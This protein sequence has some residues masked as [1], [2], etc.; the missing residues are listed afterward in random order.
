ML[1]VSPS[2]ANALSPHAGARAYVMFVQ[3]NRG[4]ILIEAI[5][6]SEL[7]RRLGELASDNAYDTMLIG[8]LETST[9]DVHAKQIHEQCEDAH[10][11]HSWFQPTGDLLA[12]VQGSGQRALQELLAVTHPAAIS[13]RIVDVKEMADMLG[14]SIPTVRRMVKANQIPV[15]RAPD[16]VLR[17]NPTD[18]FASLQ[19]R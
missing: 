19:R 3:C 16:R 1:I 15:I 4:P 18:V 8:L 6:G 7:G 13:D 2:T 17:F 11:H 5:K 10:L 9:P 12:F 14:V